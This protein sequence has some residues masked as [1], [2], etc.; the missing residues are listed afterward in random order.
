[1]IGISRLYW[2]LDGSSDSF[3]NFIQLGI[4]ID[5]T[6]ESVFAQKKKKRNTNRYAFV[7]LVLSR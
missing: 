7:V 1:M 3:D 2:L 5:V 6:N 4:N